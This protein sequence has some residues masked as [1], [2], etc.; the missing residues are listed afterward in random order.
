MSDPIIDP[1]L[2]L[3]RHCMQQIRQDAEGVW[4]HTK[5]RATW[6]YNS[7][8]AEPPEAHSDT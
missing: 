2:T 5:N 6:C 7:T 1:D 4:R 8:V 3:C